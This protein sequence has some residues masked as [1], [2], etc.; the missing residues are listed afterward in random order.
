MKRILK[1]SIL[2]IFNALMLSIARCSDSDLWRISIV[3]FLYLF[4]FIIIFKPQKS[5]YGDEVK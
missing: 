4:S 3:I 5:K 1:L 2:S